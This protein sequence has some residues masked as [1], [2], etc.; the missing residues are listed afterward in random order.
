MTKQAETAV[1]EQAQ[2]R[3]KGAQKNYE[4]MME[5]IAP[6]VKKRVIRPSTEL[7][8]WKTAVSTEFSG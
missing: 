8:R 7:D 5:R 6:F 4:K 2:R 1:S 3:L